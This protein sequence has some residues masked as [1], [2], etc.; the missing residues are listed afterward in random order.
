ME[1]VCISYIEGQTEFITSLQDFLDDVA[2]LANLQLGGLML[3]GLGHLFE[4]YI[5]LLMMAVPGQVDDVLIARMDN[6]TVKLAETENQQLGLLANASTLA[7]E[8]LPRAVTKLLPAQHSSSK[9][10]LTKRALEKPNAE[11][12]EWKRRWQRMADKLRDHYC[13]QQVLDLIFPEDGDSK[14]SFYSYLDL[15]N[16]GGR[17]EPLPSQ[18]FQVWFMFSYARSHVN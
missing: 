16:D 7:E 2:P 8:I 9:E 18:L 11:L 1:A 3:D 4:S 13:M 14:F 6:K 5:E 15:D 17:L 12:R 10:P